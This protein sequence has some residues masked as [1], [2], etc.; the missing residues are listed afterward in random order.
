MRKLIISLAIPFLL[1][2]CGASPTVNM[3]KQGRFSQYPDKTIGQA[4][5]NFFG[6]PSWKSFVGENGVDVVEFNGKATIDGQAVKVK[7]QFTVDK[8]SGSFEVAHFS[9]NDLSQNLLTLASLEAT[10][11]SQAPSAP[12][13]GNAE[14]EALAKGVLRTLSTAAETYATTNNGAY[15]VDVDVLL[16][17]DQP[18]INQNYCNETTEGYAYRCSFSADG[19]KFEAIPTQGGKPHT[20]VTGG[21]ES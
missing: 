18:Y 20:M 15:P 16:K 4:F 1:I 17:A 10:I 2:G 8:K 14:A 13:G 6:S 3:V 19:Y 7:I 21:V 5:D 9:V 12:Q 11:F